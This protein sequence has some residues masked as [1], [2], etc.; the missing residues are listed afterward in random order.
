MIW[1]TWRQH[2]PEALIGAA[3]AAAM[4]TATVVVASTIGLARFDAVQV[5][6]L[7]AA[8]LV[9]PALVGVFVGAPLIARDL[10]QGL[11]RLVWTQ[12]VTRTRW[13]W[14]KLLLVFTAVAAGAG[15]V[16]G[17]VLAL[18]WPSQQRADH[19]RWFDVQ[20]PAFAAYVLF[21][22]ALGVAV[23]V[24]IG[25]S[26]PAMAV[27]F[28]LFVATRV[29]VGAF[30]RPRFMEPLR[31]PISSFGPTQLTAP[32]SALFVG[33]RFFDA[34]GHERSIDDLLHLMNQKQ[35]GDSLSAYGWTGWSYYQPDTRFWPFQSIETAIFLGLT[36]LLV[37]LTF[38]WLTRRAR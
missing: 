16:G 35:L 29:A 10:E 24:V 4:A 36:A 28:L 13:L 1:A 11:H 23:G 6:D 20:V 33:D 15:L 34:G 21:A 38:G 12:G 18:Q 22:L 27:T 7:D 37:G 8:L 32:P 17:V 25:R 26:Y 9:L 2:R 19:W 30:L 3:V 5:Q 14:A 31:F